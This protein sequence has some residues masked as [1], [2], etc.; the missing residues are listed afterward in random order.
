MFYD[1]LKDIKPKT[2]DQVVDITAKSHNPECYLYSAK[3]GNVMQSINY[4]DASPKIV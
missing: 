2:F 3:F 4:D 1:L